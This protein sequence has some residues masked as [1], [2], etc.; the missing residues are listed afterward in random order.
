M[1]SLH[2]KLLFHRLFLSI[3]GNIGK[4]TRAATVSSS[5]NLIRQVQPEE[6]RCNWQEGLSE[7]ETLKT[8][9]KIFNS[10]RKK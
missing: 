7:K 1:I 10:N 9:S 2:F 3:R 4:V 5:A 8:S 6:S